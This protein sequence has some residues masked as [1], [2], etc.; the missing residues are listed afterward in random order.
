[1]S[2]FQLARLTGSIPWLHTKNTKSQNMRT[3]SNSCRA[4]HECAV[5]SQAQPHEAFYRPDTKLSL[6]F[7]A[8]QEK[9][10]PNCRLCGL[11][12]LTVWKFG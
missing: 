3:H 6:S 9:A 8:L 12:A 4:P 5:V 11:S 7:S 1:M 2:A 10:V